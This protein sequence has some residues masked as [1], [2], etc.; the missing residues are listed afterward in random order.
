MLLEKLI[1]LHDRKETEIGPLYHKEDQISWIIQ[2]T[3]GGEF[4]QLIET[5]GD[6]GGHMTD[7]RSNR[8][9]TV[10]VAPYLI[11]DK[12]YYV[13][14]LK[15]G[16]FDDEGKVEDRHQ[17]YLDLV[18][19]CRNETG[20]P[21]VKAVEDF[22]TKPL[23]KAKKEGEFN[24]L[25]PD[26]MLTFRV[27]DKFVHQL[28]EVRNFWIEREEKRSSADSE[29]EAN[30]MLCGEHKPIA[31]RHPVGSQL[32]QAGLIT[33]NENAFESYGLNNSE[34]APL[35]QKC[36]LKYGRTLRY[37]F[38]SDDHHIWIGGVTF[39]YW[40]E[41]PTSFDPMNLLEE[42]DTQE[43]ENL[44]ETPL[45]GR[46]EQEELS[47]KFYALSATTN[48]SRLVIRDWLETTIGEVKQNLAEF[49]DNQQIVNNSGETGRPLS[50]YSLAGSLVRDFDDLSPNVIPA[51]IN[52]AL[53]GVNLPD[54]ILTQ[55]MK[56]ARADTDNRM[57]RPRAA[58][59]KMVLNQ[60][61][62]QSEA[63]RMEEKLDLQNENP[64]YLCGRLLG[65]L[66]DIQEAAQ[67]GINSTIVDRFYGTASSSPVSVF[68]NLIRKSQNHLSKLRNT[69]EGAHH[70]LQEEL[71]EVLS[72]L[73]GFPKTLSY[74]EQGQ[75]SLGYY[76]QRAKSRAEAIKHAKEKEEE[77]S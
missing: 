68:G 57:T 35:C 7:Y 18:Q 61:A 73:D 28:D 27:K 16:H 23:K 72:K 52:N 43:V 9:R 51:L 15:L 76:H 62:K 64:A 17:A 12:P 30:C 40:T 49:F 54:W 14:G 21:Y 3:K 11:V 60:K 47:N 50:V 53:K 66:E 29:L 39:A 1:S 6:R 24:E 38:S 34:I 25:D 59:I 20:N 77:T 67:P 71:E 19:D 22:L 13:L 46:E 32:G 5:S 4:Q 58:L 45:T 33:A 75:F 44:L 36:A 37:L 55:A 48:K 8:V 42:P 56:R 2:I 10:N 41:N 31:K 69:N 26:D 74:E 63:R 70:A 65:I